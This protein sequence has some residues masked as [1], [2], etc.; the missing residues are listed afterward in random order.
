MDLAEL[1]VLHLYGRGVRVYVFRF[2]TSL[3]IKGLGDNIIL[4]GDVKK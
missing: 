4:Q 3:G 2:V 1:Q